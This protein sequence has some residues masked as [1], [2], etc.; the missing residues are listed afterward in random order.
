MKR[1]L[2]ILVVSVLIVAPFTGKGGATSADER[3]QD[4]G[5]YHE[6]SSSVPVSQFLRDAAQVSALPLTAVGNQDNFAN[7]YE[8]ETGRFAILNFSAPDAPVSNPNK[9]LIDGRI[10][11]ELNLDWIDLMPSKPGPGYNGSTQKSVDDAEFLRELIKKAELGHLP[12]ATS[13][14]GR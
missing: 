9:A 6:H 10:F 5:T 2:A 1:F 7:I 14:L 13:A 4:E 12:Q 8:G 11:D 3:F